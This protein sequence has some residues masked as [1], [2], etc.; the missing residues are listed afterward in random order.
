MNAIFDNNFCALILV[1][2]TDT[3]PESAMRQFDVLPVTK[4]ATMEFVRS[5]DADVVRLY[6]AG[7]AY[8]TIGRQLGISRHT[9]FQTIKRLRAGGQDLPQRLPRKAVAV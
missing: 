9:A 6:R 7:L 8:E 3:D 5:R 4:P 2:L 1:C